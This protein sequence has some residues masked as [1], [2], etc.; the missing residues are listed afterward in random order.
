MSSTQAQVP[1]PGPTQLLFDSSPSTN[2]YFGYALAAWEDWLAIGALNDVDPAGYRNG[3]VTLFQRMAS[4]RF[5]ERQVLGSSTPGP[6][7]GKFG[8]SV[9]I[10]Q[11]RLIVAADSE[12]APNGSRRGVVHAYELNPASGIWV[13]TQ[14]LLDPPNVPAGSFES[15]GVR[16]WMD[17]NHLLVGARFFNG[18]GHGG[19]VNYHFHDGTRWNYV[20][21]LL[22]QLPLA[23]YSEFGY[24]LD[25]D[26]DAGLVAVGARSQNLTGLPIESGAGH[27]FRLVGDGS[28]PYQFVYDSVITPPV[29]LHY[30]RFGQTCTVIDDEHVAFMPDSL[31]GL[32]E[33]QVFRRAGSGWTVDTR[34]PLPQGSSAPVA[35]ID[36]SRGILHVGAAH[37]NDP[38][39]PFGSGALLSFCETAG[40]WN[41]A[42]IH[43]R[44]VG[45]DGAFAR[46]ALLVAEDFVAVSASDASYSG[47]L[48][49][50][51]VA[52]FPRLEPW[53]CV[54]GTPAQTICSATTAGCPGGS[55]GPY[56]DPDAGCLNSTGQQGRLH[57]HGIPQMTF[58]TNRALATGLPPGEFALLLR[59]WLTVVGPA[60]WDPAGRPLGAGTLCLTRPMMHVYPVKQVTPSGTAEWRDIANFVPGQWNGF[61]SWTQNPFQVWYRDRDPQG[62]ATSNTTNALLI[63]IIR[64]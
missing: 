3:V 39:Q 33:C 6:G 48:Y 26:A 54:R 34:I 64:N 19:R 32:D 43:H 63:P 8:M 50:G 42:R 37:W 45:V 61:A 36:Y 44:P 40:Y 52:I 25:A 31:A 62:G 30:G 53:D 47:V 56:P 41:M 4:G 13:E 51:A 24:S 2:G 17:G 23:P 59:G 55:P 16:L 12:W 38:F 29:P 20:S 28:T 27:V 1:D 15:T 49:A 11:G 60:A 10:D 58:N 5:V 14:L 18:G 7:I 21:D 57:F 22:P 9:A 46:D 35:K